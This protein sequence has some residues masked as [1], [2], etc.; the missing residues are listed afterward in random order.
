MSIEF[1]GVM[2]YVG[3]T[4]IVGF[5]ASRG[6][7]TEDDYLLAGRRIGPMLAIFTTFATWFGAETCI[8]SAGSIYTD[9]LGGSTADPF[10]YALCLVL[11]GAV[12][13]VPLWRLQITTLADLFR[14]RFGV[15]VERL[16]T[17]LVVPT[18]LMWGAAQIRA[19]GQVL[20]TT[21]DIG[22]FWATTIAAGVVIA[23]TVSG[24]LMADVVTDLVQGIALILGLLVLGS[25]VVY[26]FDGSVLDHLQALPADKLALF[27]TAETP[28]FERIEM[29]AIPIFGSV[30]S[31]ELVARV[32]AVRDP[33]IARRST[34]IA[35]GMYLLVG[36][37][38]VAIGL[39]G[40][41]LMPDLEHAEQL[42]P[43]VARQ[44][45]PPILYIMFA[46][47]L[48]SAILSTVDSALLVA[49]SLT[50]HNLV[51]SLKPDLSDTARVRIAR[52]LVVVFGV[53]AY[54][55]ALYAEGVYALVEEASAF[56]SSGVFVVAT[57][58][59]FTKF[60]GIRAALASLCTGIMVYILGAYLT[61]VHAPYLLSL[62]AAL[63]A[64]LLVAVTEPAFAGFSP[65]ATQQTH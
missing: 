11:M 33:Y 39:L 8:G 2:G 49:A 14:I 46:G 23:Y 52:M 55:M 54:A 57:L 6:V 61:Q 13:A 38:P 7:Q 62:G 3:L 20:T 43:A 34:L 63:A 45:L 22:L 5:W 42:L 4:L 28:L 60:G 10:G 36:L 29:W 58:G 21:S 53:M 48:V 9:G 41:T 26:Q 37:I 25:V 30:L 15:S 59:L 50:E 27:G 16:V 64:Y 35:S 18:S 31:Q 12:F 56:G 51:V 1:W 44:M 40:P 65:S 19:F 32:M 24:G 47:A 17:L